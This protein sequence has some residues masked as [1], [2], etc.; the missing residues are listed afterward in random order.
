[1]KTF[2]LLIIAIIFA[3]SCKEPQEKE[4]TKETITIKTVNSD[5]LL[6]ALHLF[7][8]PY[9]KINAID[10]IVAL[11]GRP[12]RISCIPWGEHVADSM[13]TVY[14]DFEEFSFW[15]NTDSKSELSSVILF[16]KKVLLPGNLSV[17]KSTRKDIL[18]NLGL[19]DFDYNDPGRSLT[20]SGDT[21]VYINKQDG[22][23]D[24]SFTY[25][26]NTDEY[27]INLI[28]TKDILKKVCWSKNPN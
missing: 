25:Y 27:A 6:N 26:I 17:G 23:E 16:D 9:F 1:M 11:K 22:G 21:T 12:I 20:K 19:P 5:S 7:A 10:S 18:Q 2:K 4:K 8:E 28:M 24:V 15:K 3:S 14:Y 13:L